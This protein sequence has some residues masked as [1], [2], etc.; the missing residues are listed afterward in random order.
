MA[1]AASSTFPQ[2]LLFNPLS[3]RRSIAQLLVLGVMI[4][5][6]YGNEICAQDDWGSRVLTLEM[7]V[8]VARNIYRDEGTSPLSYAGPAAASNWKL[9]L[10]LGYWDLALHSHT[11]LGIYRDALAKGFAL[12]AAGL[13]HSL[14]IK[15]MKRMRNSYLWLGTSLGD[16]LGVKYNKHHENASVGVTNFV[17]LGL[18]AKGALSYS[19]LHKTLFR[20]ARPSRCWLF[21]EVSLLPIGVVLRPGYTFIDN[22]AGANNLISTF[23]SN[24]S[25]HLRTL[26]GIATE[27]G[28]QWHLRSLRRF[29]LSYRWAFLASGEGDT[30]WKY[31][32]AFHG[33]F[34]AFT[35]PLKEL[36]PASTL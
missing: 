13:N 23:G 28:I 10:N 4:C 1:Q 9:T 35:F 7:G 5:G 11:T 19:Q 3:R 25:W 36:K 17:A 26:P 18:H 6:C 32:S 8:G 21:G 29:S 20:S 34:L 22:Y 12:D 27:V 24:Y 30:G 16:I 33:L 14:Y 15:A 31:Q 2:F